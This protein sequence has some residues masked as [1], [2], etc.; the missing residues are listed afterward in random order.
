MTSTL[1]Q[2]ITSKPAVP[3]HGVA[4]TNMSTVTLVSAR[5]RSDRAAEFAGYLHLA[6]E[7][8]IDDT[9]TG[10]AVGWKLA[11]RARRAT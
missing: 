3:L 1:K 2:G 5:K 10:T 9:F 7:L 8:G 6:A 4:M 11:F